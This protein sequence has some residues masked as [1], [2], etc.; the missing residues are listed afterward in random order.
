MIHDVP[1]RCESRER[2]SL[3]VSTTGTCLEFLALVT[4]DNQGKVWS[5]TSL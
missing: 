2:T 4:F 5:S 3:F 1:S